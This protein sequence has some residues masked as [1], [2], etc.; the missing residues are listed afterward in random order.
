MV[1]I[2]FLLL[3]A[4]I[5]AGIV[6]DHYQRISLEQTNQGRL[7]AIADLKAQQVSSWLSE[8]RANADTILKSPFT[9][10]SIQAFTT[11]PED[12]QNQEE[13]FTWLGSLQKNYN[14]QSVILLSVQAKSLLSAPAGIQTIGKTAAG[15]SRQAIQTRQ[16]VFSDLYRDEITQHLTLDYCVPLLIGDEP[17]MTVIGLVLLRIDPDTSLYPLLDSWPIASKT[18]ETQLVRR[19][20]DDVIFL[21]RIERIQAPALSLRL[22]ANTPDLPAA[23]AVFG[24]PGDF[25]GVSEEN[26]PVFAALRRIPD[27]P[28]YLVIQVDQDEIYQPLAERNRLLLVVSAVL[29]TAAGTL[30]GM[31]WRQREA[32]FYKEEYL[33]EVRRQALS[34]HLLL[35]SRYSNDIILLS[36]QHWSLLEANDR[37]VSAY[38]YSLAELQKMSMPQLFSIETRVNFSRQIQ[39]LDEKEGLV[40]EATHQ[41]KDGFTFPVEISARTIR[42]DGRKF[43]Q[44]IIRDITER[45][46]AEEALRESERRFRL[47]YEQSP[48]GYQSLDEKACFIDVNPA[49]LATFGYERAAVIGRYFPD[50]LTPDSKARFEN[51]FAEFEGAG[52]FRSMEFEL[53]CGTGEVMLISVNGKAGYDEI[54]RLGQIH[55]ILHDITEQRRA[56]EAIRKMNEELEQRVL[57]RTTQFEAANKELE[58]FSYSVSHDLRAPLRAIDGFSRILSEEYTAEL[59]PEAHRYLDLVRNNAQT[60]S[61]LIDNLLAFSRL[62]RQPLKKQRVQPNEVVTQSLDLLRLEHGERCPDWQRIDLVVHPLPLCDADPALLK[63][64]FVNLLSNAIKFSSKK[65]RSQIEVGCLEENHEKIYFVRDNGVGFDM[66]YAPKLFG[67]FQRLHRVEDYEG[68]GVGLAIVQRII[69]RHGGRVWA[70]GEVDQGA[71]FCFTLQEERIND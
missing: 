71:T 17:Q 15:F 9:A 49:W 5:L 38:Q 39:P 12:P 29:I 47:F 30:T 10:A 34:E 41:R 54:G 60:M 13:I 1:L 11:H 64:V 31:L 3:F 55:F 45:K 56:E 51:L 21:N 58:A 43:Y 52:E 50:F 33:A 67:V 66:K 20:G 35:I 37:A 4:L 6:S 32:R 19:E 8:R 16:I 70:L 46:Q 65:E 36:N 28:W 26:V 7:A 62:G 27:S 42:V 14:Y 69:H 53:V 63:Q 57:E 61:N 44:S 59:S 24:Q 23:Q 68:T 40:F 18:G 2:F 22:P 25:K 48:V